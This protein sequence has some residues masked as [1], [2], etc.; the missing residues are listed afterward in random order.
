[1]MMEMKSDESQDSL[2]VTSC[3]SLS[4]NQ[5]PE[6]AMCEKL[7]LMATYISVDV[8]R[9][10]ELSERLCG[11][12]SGVNM[13]GTFGAGI[14][15]RLKNLARAAEVAASKQRIIADNLRGLNIT[16]VIF[17]EVFLVR[18]SEVSAKL[19]IKKPKLKRYQKV[20][21]WTKRRKGRS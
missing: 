14:E 9:A 11:Q 21:P 7:A 18:A 2:T 3:E 1:M 10:R 6:D 5:N 19:S 12:A 8:E 13:G 15:V 20:K 16:F 4:N 17:D